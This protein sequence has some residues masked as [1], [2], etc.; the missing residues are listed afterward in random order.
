MTNTQGSAS[1]EAAFKA[2]DKDGSGLLDY[3]EFEAVAIK[4]GFGA[5]AYNIFRSLDQDF[6]GAVSYKELIASVMSNSGSLNPDVTRLCTSLMLAYQDDSMDPVYQAGLDTSKW[7]IR[8][9]DVETIRSE[10]QDLLRKSG[11]HV[12]DL[13]KLFDQDHDTIQEI[14]DIEFCTAMRNKLGFKGNG[15]LL[16]DVFK[17]LDVSGDGQIGFVRMQTRSPYDSHNIHATLPPPP[18]AY[19]RVAPLPLRTSCLSLSGAVAIHSTSVTLRSRECA[20]RLL[21]GQVAA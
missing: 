13:L 4:M 8:G 19:N 7:V 16:F 10:L 9:N 3:K 20:S 1:L 21:K 12:T 5:V 18:R 11:A 6:S 15:K 2:H 17:S 14:D